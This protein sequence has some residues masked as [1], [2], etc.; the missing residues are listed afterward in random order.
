MKPFHKKY[1]R[2]E[3]YRDSCGQNFLKIFVKDIE[4]FNG[5]YDEYKTSLVK[6]TIEAMKRKTK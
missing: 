6:R 3:E 4:V 2:E 5:L 1:Y